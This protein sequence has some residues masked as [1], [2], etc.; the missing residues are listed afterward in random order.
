MRRTFTISGEGPIT[1]P[2][3]EPIKAARYSMT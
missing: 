3:L 2:L 1:A